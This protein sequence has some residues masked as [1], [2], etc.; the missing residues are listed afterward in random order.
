M[1]QLPPDPD[2]LAAVEEDSRR[3]FLGTRRDPLIRAASGA[4]VYDLDA[5]SFLGEPAPAT[6]HPVLWE[7]SRRVARHGLFEV[8]EGVFQVRGFDLANLTLVEGES[9]VVVID[10]LTCT[11]T[12]EAALELYFAHRGRR[13]VAGVVLTHPHVDH[14]G[15]VA[16]VLRQ[17]AADPVP[18]L[19]PEGFHHHATSE[20]VVAGP[21]MR[22]RSGYMYGGALPAGPAGHVGCGLGQR[23]AAGTTTLT[24]PTDS[25]RETGETR[26]ID[27]V[28]LEF[29]LTP[30]TEA[31]AEMNIFLPQRGALCLAENAVHTL[32]NIITLRGAQVR[33]AKRW[34]AYLDETRRLFGHRTEVA[35]ATHH[36]PTWGRERVDEF[37]S[38][39]RDVYGF[40]HDQTVRLM[41]DGLTPEEIAETLT[42]PAALA[43]SPVVRGFYGSLSHNVKGIYQFYLGWYDGSPAHLWKLPHR[44]GA[45]RWIDLL[46]GAEKAVGHARRLLFGEQAE[47]A[48]APQRTEAIRTASVEDLRFAAEL[49]DACVFAQPAPAPGAPPAPASD[50]QADA[51]YA[52]APYAEAR[53]LLAAV[54]ER[55]AHGCENAVWRN[56]Y[57]TGAAELR[58]SS[59]AR[60]ARAA[61]EAEAAR[62]AGPTPAAAPA[63]GS[64]RGPVQGR[65]QLAQG[66]GPADVLDSCAVRLD[67]P[68][69]A[70]TS[71]SFDLVELDAAGEAVRVHRAHLRNGVLRHSCEEIAGRTEHTATD[72]DPEAQLSIRVPPGQAARLAH[73][74][75]D[76]FD[77]S[78][79]PAVWERFRSL[80]TTPRRRFPIVAPH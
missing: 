10:T 20:N 55:L 11:E 48:G 79:D 35:F 31:P 25:I 53:E 52:E 73:A 17:G 74:G 24:E 58:M 22:R 3:G 46:G 4:E 49:L 61:G 29:Q 54:F 76:G 23:V 64:P 60:A 37:L 42:L 6:A 70:E 19:A 44:A 21:A 80:L 15:G 66:L 1:T 9:G 57:L 32:H 7:H 47:A 41:N 30:G 62:A 67:G 69:A 34:S 39:Q 16:A 77:H 75:L 51:P 45:R 2:A 26:E 40:M 28:L 36:W 14:F 13:P 65:N 12:A 78:G 18:V 50:T 27:G 59:P 68:A 38:V 63:A 71:L 72:S 33:D 5:Y 8:C 56:E 43:A